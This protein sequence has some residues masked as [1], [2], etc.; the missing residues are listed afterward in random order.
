MLWSMRINDEGIYRDDN[1][2]AL[3]NAGAIEVITPA[4]AQKFSDDGQSL[5]LSNDKSIP[6]DVVIF[7]TGYSSSWNGVI[8]GMS[9]LVLNSSV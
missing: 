9:V 1:F 2:H 4:R 5:I 6:A 8:E 3:V 7:A